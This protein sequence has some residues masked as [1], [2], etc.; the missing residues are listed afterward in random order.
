MSDKAEKPSAEERIDALSE[1]L[2]AQPL[3]DERS[4]R[5]FCMDPGT[6]VAVIIEDGKIIEYA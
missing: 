2:R 1:I 6:G 3:S 4:V 5:L